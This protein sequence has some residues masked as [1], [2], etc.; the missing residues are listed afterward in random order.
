M[1]TIPNSDLLV[2]NDG[3]IYHLS[4][5]PD[6]VADTVI[7]VGDPERVQE[8]SHYFDR[9]DHR[10][11][12]RE[13]VTHTGICRG[14]HL[15][16]LSTGIGTDNIDIV[17][18]ELDA[19]VNIDLV[20][21]QAKP[22]ARSLTIIRIGTSG[23]I[24]PDIPVNS[25][26]LSSYGLSFDN[27]LHFYKDNGHIY[28]TELENAFIEQVKWNRTIAAPRIIR[29]SEELIKKLEKGTT[30]GIT[31]TAP[32]FY[33]PQGR[34]LRLPL[35]DPDLNSKIRDFSYKGERI[36]NFEME[37]SALYGLGAML[38]HKTATVCALIANRA[39]NT[40][41]VDHKLVIRNLVEMVLERIT[42]NG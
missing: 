23:A 36:I 28:E 14:K 5:K 34:V 7:I 37:T 3:S 16:V 12:N 18:N 20:K 40:Y 10:V 32:G 11:R 41:S 31:V 13:F 6:Q 21:R 24:Q 8:I 2:H 17:I 1:Y 26:A 27:L 4:L 25:F 19:L 30:K 29:G 39:N 15:T 42:S 33:G 9:V 22:Q 38:G 35:A